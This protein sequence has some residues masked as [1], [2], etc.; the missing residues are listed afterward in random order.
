MQREQVEAAIDATPKGANVILEWV[1]PLTP[2]K[3][4]GC[5]DTIVKATRMVGRVGINYDNQAAVIA[6]RENG[7]LPAENQG[8]R[9]ME[10]VKPPYLMKAIK[11]G[12][13][14]IR[15]YKGT[16][17][18]VKPEVHYFRNGV[19]VERKSLKGIVASKDWKPSTKGDCFSCHTDDITRI[20]SESEWMMVVVKEIEQEKVAVSIPIPAKVL[21]TL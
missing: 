15:L 6:K 7:E 4:S 19:E 8:L 21:A 20:H 14:L 13:Y 10:W 18:K 2:L 9:G 16:S 1:R 17:A 12:R 11:S 3:T 5:N